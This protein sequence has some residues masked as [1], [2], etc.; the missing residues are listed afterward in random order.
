MSWWRDI[1]NRRYIPYRVEDR[2]FTTGQRELTVLPNPIHTQMFQKYARDPWAFY[3]LLFG[4]ADLVPCVF[5]RVRY[6]RLPR[7][8]GVLPLRLPNQLFVLFADNYRTAAERVVEWCWWKGLTAGWALFR[9]HHHHLRLSHSKRHPHHHHL[10]LAEAKVGI[11]ARGRAFVL[12]GRRTVRGGCVPRSVCTSQRWIQLPFGTI[13]IRL[14]LQ[15]VLYPLG[16]ERSFWREG[17]L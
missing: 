14:Y 5:G 6:E 15:F 7:R 8:G 1:Y 13:S 2:R 11:P 3:F 17:G 4:S 10:R 16:G 12:V 9:K